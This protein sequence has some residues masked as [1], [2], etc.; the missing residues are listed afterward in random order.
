VATKKISGILQG[1]DF[2]G[3]ETKFQNGML[4]TAQTI[5]CNPGKGVRNCARWAQIDPTQIEPGDL[6]APFVLVAGTDGVVQ[7]TVIGSDWAYRSF[8]SI[9]VNECNDMAVGYSY[10]A[11]PANSGGSWYPSIFV[12]GR[13]SSDPIGAIGGEKMLLKGKAAYTSFQD[14]GGVAPV[15]WGDYTGM[16]LDP[17]GRTFW[18]VGEYSKA[19]VA[20][21]FANWATFVGSFQYGAVNN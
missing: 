14:N 16:T 17:D 9:A 4:W 7:A 18:Y 8:P 2:R 10:S 13:K 5:S 12:A 19:N 1:N 11:A 20:N 15:R 3:Q 6:L 21:D